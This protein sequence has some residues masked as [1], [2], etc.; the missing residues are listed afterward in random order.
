MQK[1]QELYCP[2]IQDSRDENHYICLKCQQERQI[3]QSNGWEVFLMIFAVVVLL[4]LLTSCTIQN[5]RITEAKNS[6]Y[7]QNEQQ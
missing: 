2:W 4:A 1:C 7:I 6:H 3:N 5:N